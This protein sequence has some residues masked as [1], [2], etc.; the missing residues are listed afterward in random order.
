MY[1]QVIQ[2]VTEKNSLAFVINHCSI[3]IFFLLH[4]VSL[5]ID[6][7][8][9]CIPVRCLPP[10]CCLYLPACTAPRGRYTWSGGDLVLG[11]GVY[12]VPGGGYLVPGVYLVLGVVYLVPG[13]VPAQVP[14]YGQN[15]GRLWKYNLAPTSLRPVMMFNFTNTK[16]TWPSNRMT[17]K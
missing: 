3:P 2:N 6:F 16:E 8:Q 17:V 7:K 10:A 12:L 13:G 9:E 15:H 1:F 14:P 5:E 11:E 4:C